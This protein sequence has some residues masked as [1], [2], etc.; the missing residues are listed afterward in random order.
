MQGR[1]STIHGFCGAL[2]YYRGFFTAVK[3]FGSDTYLLVGVEGAFRH[4]TS[5]CYLSM[6]FKKHWWLLGWVETG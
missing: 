4:R 3:A 2:H 5:A 1:E 6:V